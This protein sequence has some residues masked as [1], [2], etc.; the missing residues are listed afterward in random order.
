MLFCACVRLSLSTLLHTHRDKPRSLGHKECFGRKFGIIYRF[1]TLYG[2]TS[3][4]TP[5]LLRVLALYTTLSC[6]PNILRPLSLQRC[7]PSP[8]LL[9]VVSP[10]QHGCRCRP[11]FLPHLFFLIS[12]RRG[13]FKPF[14]FYSLRTCERVASVSVALSGGSYRAGWQTMPRSRAYTDVCR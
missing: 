11:F 7:I 14:L 3:R 13:P 1:T 6:R 2:S 8:E 4:N 9:Y 5:A 12:F 10:L